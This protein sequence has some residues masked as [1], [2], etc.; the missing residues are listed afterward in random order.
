ML[1]FLFHYVTVIQENSCMCQQEFSC[2]RKFFMIWSFR[3]YV[4][5]GG[6]NPVEDWMDEQPLKA[7]LKIDFRLLYLR[8]E[9]VWPEAYISALKGHPDI[10]ELRVVFG[11]CQYRPLGC[12]GPGLRVFTILL[13][14]IEKGKIPNYVITTA[15][16]RRQ[17]V[18]TDWSR[19]VEHVFRY[20]PRI[21]GEPTKQ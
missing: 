14:T 5:Q 15:E 10:Y 21:A 20:T 18:L 4:E 17:V 6:G 8:D 13:G 3:D 7:R 1:A 2:T 16:K 11:G 19:S 9:K 12:Y